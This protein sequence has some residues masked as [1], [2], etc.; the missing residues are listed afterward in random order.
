MYI[1]IET[2]KYA[3]KSNWRLSKEKMLHCSAKATTFRD[4]HGNE[5]V[6]YREIHCHTSRMHK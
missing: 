4:Q 5:Q 6:S 2:I 1:D 3:Y